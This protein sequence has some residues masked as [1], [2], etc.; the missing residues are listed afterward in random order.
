MSQDLW[1]VVIVTALA[2]LAIAVLA[3]ARQ[4]SKP[5]LAWWARVVAGAAGALLIY[6][7][8]ADPKPVTD[9]ADL[10]FKGAPGDLE[11]GRG[12]ADVL[13]RLLL[14]VAAVAFLLVPGSWMDIAAG[15]LLAL[16]VSA[17]FTHYGETSDLLACT[18]APRAPVEGCT[19][20]APTPTP[21]GGAEIAVELPKAKVVAP[22]AAID[23][24]PGV[25]RPVLA[26]HGDEGIVRTFARRYPVTLAEAVPAKKLEQDV[27]L[28][29]RAKKAKA[30]LADVTAAKT[31]YLTP[32]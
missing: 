12:A 30:L 29:I 19:T 13:A 5:P 2:A 22:L 1:L 4:L 3:I 6:L 15:T 20:P 31:I 11:L 27:V 9:V 26:V 7:A 16:L 25:I 24:G 10:L 23:A 21:P 32:R 17:T 28:N 8:I 18:K 14:V